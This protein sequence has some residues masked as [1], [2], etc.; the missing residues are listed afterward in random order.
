VSGIFFAFSI[1]SKLIPLAFLPFLIRRLGW[2][3]SL[4][5]F[6]TIAATILLLFLPYVSRE[7]FL[8]IAGSLDLYFQKFEFNASVFYLVRWV[9]F[10]VKRI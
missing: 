4:V 1:A 3:K 2:R 6:L 7:L 8:Q 5:F 9:G 10:M